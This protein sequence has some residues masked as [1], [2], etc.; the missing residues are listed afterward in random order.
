MASTL[1]VACPSCKK[2]FRVPAEFVGRLI[3][4]KNCQFAFEVPDPSVPKPAKPAAAKP[5][6]PAAPAQARP[7]RPADPSAPIPFKQEEEEDP[8]KPKPYVVVHD[9][10]D[11]PR[12]PF[13]AKELDPPDTRVC[14]NCGFNLLD[15]KRM[16]AKVVYEHTTGDYFLHWLPAILSFVGIILLFSCGIFTSVMMRTWMIG[17]FLDKEEKNVITGQ[18]EFYVKPYCF[19]IWIWVIVL[20]ISYK[21]TRFIIRRLVFN[22]RPP[23]VVKKTDD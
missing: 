6:R 21:L 18:Q 3:R 17:S 5:A 14:L 10:A 15:R 8:K 19:N 1:D 13:C 4:C 23:D 2:A 22:W 16:D 7:A 20:W 12:C 9:D 11:V